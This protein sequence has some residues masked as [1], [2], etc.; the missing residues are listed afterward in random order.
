ML[1]GAGSLGSALMNLWTRSGWGHWTVLDKDHLK[2]H[3]LV[4]SALFLGAL[5]VGYLVLPGDS[6]RIAA[7]ER[8]GKNREALR[9]LEQRFA[10]GDRSQRT[11]FQMQ[12]LLE[13]FGELT[14]A[15]KTLEMLAEQ[16]PK[17][18]Q[19]QRQL[20]QFYKLTQN[21]TGYVATLRAQL[22]IR[23]S[24]PVCKELIGIQRRNGNFTEEQRAILDCRHCFL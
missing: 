11:L 1:I 19:V 12:R 8:D 5:V 20:A 10:Q 4:M 22:E 18:A 21:E 13:H 15:R 16:R 3:N 24:E 6:E 9:I 2:P 14:K 23:Y 17:D 7:L